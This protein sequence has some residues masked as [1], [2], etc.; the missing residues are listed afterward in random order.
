MIGEASL[1]NKGEIDVNLQ[2]QSKVIEKS[3]TLIEC[4]I[5][6][7]LNTFEIDIRDLDLKKISLYLP[8]LV[9]DSSN[10]YSPFL[11][12]KHMKDLKTKNFSDLTPETMIN[13]DK[14]PK[15]NDFINQ[16]DDNLPFEFYNW[17]QNKKTEVA[18][19][20]YKLFK[21]NFLEIDSS[22]ALRVKK[23]APKYLLFV[24]KLDGKVIYPGERESF[25]KIY[26]LQ[27]DGLDRK[28]ELLSEN[29][30]CITCGKHENN[31]LSLQECKFFDWF[32][33]D[34]IYYQLLFDKNSNQS[35]ICKEC[36]VKLQEGYSNFDTI[37]RLEAYKIKVKKDTYITIEHSILPLVNSL[38]KIK[39]FLNI[40]KNYRE[41]HYKSKQSTLRKNFERL[42]EELDRVDKKNKKEIQNKIKNLESKIDKLKEQGELIGT[43]DLP[44]NEI[45][46]QA[47]ENGISLMDFYYVEE[48]LTGGNKKKVVK[49]VIVADKNRI[50][51]IVDWLQKTDSEFN[52]TIKFE[53]GHLID[54][55][56][57][58]MGRN[59]I[60]SLFNGKK[61]DRRSLY[62]S[63]YNNLWSL[64][65]DT[66]ITE[67]NDNPSDK[68]K[69]IT[70]KEIF[71][72]TLSLIDLAQ[73]I[74]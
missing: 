54:V 42:Q 44:Y 15:I 46:K 18:E 36:K 33:M 34:Q 7:K 1:G 27:K 49:D 67:R 32:S 5:D 68:W 62:R 22:G 53:F 6:L 19:A 37:L 35:M 38:E 39:H 17:I 3:R 9:S 23:D 40:M 25:H 21:N 61:I 10:N 26:L 47:A 13:F 70:G 52:N 28:D 57:E 65:R 74:K 59:I 60:Q 43:K 66:T 41:E 72:Y 29:L 51:K 48:M 24:F 4:I 2:H 56:G 69:V 73:I 50:K 20:V 58:K 12:I 31:L 45:L 55:F 8:G 14:L 71:H 63:A 16:I 11:V 64:F 30:V